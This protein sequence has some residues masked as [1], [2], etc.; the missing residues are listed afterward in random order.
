MS[1]WIVRKKLTSPSCS[2]LP[3]SISGM[4]ISGLQTRLFLDRCI[5]LFLFL[6]A[7]H[8][9]HQKQ[10]KKVLCVWTATGP[11]AKQ[12]RQLIITY[13][14]LS[15]LNKCSIS[16]ITELSWPVWSQWRIRINKFRIHFHHQNNH[17][18]WWKWVNYGNNVYFLKCMT[19]QSNPWIYNSMCCVYNVTMFLILPCETLD[20]VISVGAVPVNTFL[21]VKHSDAQWCEKIIFKLC[22][23]W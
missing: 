6:T 13:N 20:A 14:V 17:T 12:F 8:I 15:A 21:Q 18:W 7:P 19:I 4:L 10:T 1:W 9:G 16:H 3:D 23:P 2:E 22:F 11:N 5:S